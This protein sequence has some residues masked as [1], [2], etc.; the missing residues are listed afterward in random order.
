M[1]NNLSRRIVT[2]L[3][4]LKQRVG[5]IL[6]D[7]NGKD[8]TYIYP[9]N[10]IGSIAADIELLAGNELHDKNL[11]LQNINIELELLSTTDQLTGLFNRRKMDIELETERVRASRYKHTFSIIMFDI[12]WFKN[13]NDSYGHQIGDKVLVEVA[14]LTQ[15]TLRTTDIV[16]R[17]GGDE[18]LI[19]CP[20]TNLKGVKTMT[21]N[22]YDAVAN[23]HFTTDTAI[24]ISIGAC[25]FSGNTNVEGMLRQVDKKLYE[26]KRKGRNQ[27]V[28]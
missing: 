5:D 7:N 18:F 24:T 28:I 12:D 14:T 3:E 17:W 20:E 15:T 25:E 11:T 19:L 26:A 21:N 13:I 2:P 22:L 27:I 6:T 16:S 8:S 1:S 9:N 4:K 10:E 23:H